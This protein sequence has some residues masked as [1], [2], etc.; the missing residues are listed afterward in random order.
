MN[1]LQDMVRDVVDRGVNYDDALCALR[2][3]AR[4]YG[5]QH[6][7]IPVHAETD[8]AVQIRDVLAEAVG[9]TTAE[10]IFN[11]IAALYGGVQHYIPLETR[12]F[13]KQ[14]AIEVHDTYD[15]TQECMR[16][17][18]RKYNCSLT[19]IYRLW[20]AGKDKSQAEFLQG[21]AAQQSFDF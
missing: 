10:Q 18:C 16:E 14:I 8:L 19:Q 6:I 17:L 7:Y 20:H 15:G 1:L 13:K 3:F 2:L 12:A 11:I 9:G 4:Y 21:A 5:G